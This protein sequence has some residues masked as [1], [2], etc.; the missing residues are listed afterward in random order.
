MSSP[1]FLLIEGYITR[2]AELRHVGNN[3]NSVLSFSIGVSKGR[4]KDGESLG[5]SYFDCEFWNPPE[6]VLNNILDASE[7]EDSSLKVAIRGRLQQDRWENDEGENRSRVK[8][9]VT[10]VSIPNYSENQNDDKGRGGGK[11]RNKKSNNKKSS[12]KSS[13]GRSSSRRDGGENTSKKKTRKTAEKNTG[14]DNDDDFEDNDDDD[15]VPF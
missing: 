15:N 10:T 4:D 14:R 12:R 7:D 8:I 1:N 11:S 2:N 9:A 13:G 5:S 6:K 3:D